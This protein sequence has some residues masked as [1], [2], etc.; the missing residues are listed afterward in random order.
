MVGRH[1]PKIFFNKMCL[2]KEFATFDVPQTGISNDEMTK[3]EN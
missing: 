3:T 2:L 1:V